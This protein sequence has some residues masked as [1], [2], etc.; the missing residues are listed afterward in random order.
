MSTHETV[1]ELSAIEL[2]QIAGGVF[3]GYWERTTWGWH[4]VCVNPNEDFQHPGV[5]P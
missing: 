5:S 2:E 1:R 3:S 4:F